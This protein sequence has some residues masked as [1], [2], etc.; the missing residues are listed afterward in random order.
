V[1]AVRFKSPEQR[2]E[3]FMA[4]LRQ[5]TVRTLRGEVYV[6]REGALAILDSL[7]IAYERLVLEAVSDELDAVRNTP[8]V[9]L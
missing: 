1:V 6:V 5:G 8:T 9:T 7:N 4:L 2:A 3:G